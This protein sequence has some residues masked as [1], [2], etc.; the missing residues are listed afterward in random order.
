MLFPMLITLMFSWFYSIMSGSPMI[1]ATR[2]LADETFFWVCFVF[3]GLPIGIAIACETWPV[4]K[5]PE[6][7]IVWRD[8]KHQ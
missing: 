7:P 5:E 1:E 2:F 3:L 4:K 6:A 8:A